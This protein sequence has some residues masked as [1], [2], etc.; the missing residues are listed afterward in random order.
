MRLLRRMLKQTCVYWDVDEMNEEG[1]RTFKAPVEI[2]CRWE[3][4]NEQFIDRNGQPQ[5][6]SAKVFVDRDV[7][8]LGVLW[9]PPDNIQLAEGEAIGQLTDESRPFNNP[10]AFEIR[11]FGKI[12]TLKQRKADHVL[13]TVWL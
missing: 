7:T 8:L 11:K 5:T 12:P 3:D 2:K 1:Q 9:L 6:S 13:R 4:T 10:G